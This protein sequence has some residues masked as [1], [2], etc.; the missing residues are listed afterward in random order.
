MYYR[1]IF[2]FLIFT[3]CSK[4]TMISHPIENFSCSTENLP[5]I[6]DGNSC[7]I[8]SNF[9]ICEIIE[10]EEVQY[11]NEDALMWIPGVCD[12]EV[13]G[14]IE[15]FNGDNSIFLEIV[16]K[17]HYI[18][19]ERINLSCNENYERTTFICQ[20]NEVVNVKF[21]NDLL[22]NDTLTLELRTAIYSYEGQEPGEKLNIIN[23]REDRS[24]SNIVNFW[25]RHFIG[26]DYYENNSQS[27]HA[28]LNLNGDIYEEV[29]QYDLKENVWA[30]PYERYY[31]QFGT[32][33]LGF[34]VDGKLWLRE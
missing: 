8:E 34:E 2:C 7:D 17:E 4:E 27:F 33:I 26:D 31:I 13:G 28:E 15:F 29:V 5:I 14:L 22:G 21:L 11:I 12:L 32:G 19:E 18:S 20:K 1:I 16:E 30:N 24:N 3:S 6:S 9:L 23:L 25:L 10:V